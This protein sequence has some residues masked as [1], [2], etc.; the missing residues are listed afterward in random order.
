MSDRLFVTTR[1]GL[2]TLARD[3]SRWSIAST[4]FLGDPVT[5]VL[6]D[7][8]DGAW[9]AALDL[10]HFGVKLRRS[11]DRG[12]TWEEI[13]TPAFPSPPAGVE[14]KTTMG[15]PWHWRTEKIWALEAGHPSQPGTLWCGTVPGGLFVSRDHGA[16][17]SLVRSLWDHPARKTWGGAG[18]DLPAIHSIWVDP[19]D[20]NHVLIA[21]STGG[22]W[23]TRDGG[24]SWNVVGR[25]MFAD[26][27]PPEQRFD[28]G[29]QDVHH[30]AVCAAD[31]S[32]AWV[33]H[34]NGV[35]RS[36]DCAETF[37]SI[38]GI[39]PSV[40]GFPVAVHPNHPDTAWLV[41]AAK[42]EHR[43]PVDGRVVVNRTR[44]GGKTWQQLR[45]GLPQEHAYDLVYRHALDV[46]ETGDRLAFGSTTGS[47]WITESGG[48]AWTTLS[49]HLPPVYS[50]RFSRS[51]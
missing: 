33:Q 28:P 2:F 29:A 50:V 26:F 44:D 15:N 25:G 37:V 11:R 30:L 5:V 35:F 22:V 20:A 32:R 23:R 39:Q 21:I 27:M 6:D 8:R 49:T 31:P 14:E 16:S 3:A 10:G 9:Y 4:H 18:N 17:W 36:D 51:G 41:P 7:P 42:D 40:F 13:A 43:L 46:D 34:H 19:R 47:L 38:D 12:A 48:D 24:A 45:N 1:K